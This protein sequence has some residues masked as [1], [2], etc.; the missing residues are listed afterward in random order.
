M[1]IKA[2]FIFL[3]AMALVAMV[4]NAVAP[5]RFWRALGG[6]LGI[7]HPHIGVRRCT[8]CGRPLIGKSECDCRRKA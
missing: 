7:R 6:I 8:H 2:V 4:S 3:A 5:G 1:M